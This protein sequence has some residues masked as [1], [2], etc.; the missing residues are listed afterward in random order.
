MKYIVC[1]VTL[2]R[3]KF[4][5]VPVVFPDLMVHSVMYEAIARGLAE[6][7]T[8]AEGYRVRPLSAGSLASIDNRFECHGDSTSLKLKS[9]GS[10]DTHLLR[11]S[12]Y[13][14]CFDPR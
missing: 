13:G 9:R 14:S 2:K 5:D 7:F 1:R 10:K 3:R 6:Q 8:P 4:L 12:D 11:L